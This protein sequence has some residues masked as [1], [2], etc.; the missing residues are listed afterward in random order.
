VQKLMAFVR[1]NPELG[2]AAF[3]DRYLGGH[4]PLVLAHRSR[5]RRYVADIVDVPPEEAGLRP[6]GNPAFDAVIELWYDSIEDYL[7]PARRSDSAEGEQA[8]RADG[9]SLI[10]SVNLYHVREQVEREYARDWPAGQRSPGV[11]SIYLARRH[12]S[13]SPDQF[14]RHWGE[15][16]APLALK[17]HVGMWRY[18][19]NVV[20]AQLSEGAEAW[21]GFAELHF[22]TAQ[23]LRERFY[24]SDEGRAIIAAD[25]ARFTSGGRALHCSEYILKG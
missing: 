11:K 8:V 15:T 22:R 25:V 10:S 21:D 5:L 2:I 1:R 6:G 7:D 4:A 9:A 20:A 24:D 17:H 23:D 14:A 13:M 12:D 19:R 16:H 3:R 18:A